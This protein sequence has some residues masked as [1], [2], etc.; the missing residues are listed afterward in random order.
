MFATMR[1]QDLNAQCDYEGAETWRTI[2][3]HLLTLRRGRRA[4]KN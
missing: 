4:P 2:R 1:M 3:K